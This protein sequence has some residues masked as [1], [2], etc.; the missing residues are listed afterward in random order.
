MSDSGSDNTTASEQGKVV[1][2]RVEV[3]LGETKLGLNYTFYRGEGARFLPM[4]DGMAAPDALA[5]LVLDGWMPDEPFIAPDTTIVAFGSCFAGHIGRYLSNLG[6]DV[7]TRKDDKAYVSKLGDG[8]VNVFAIRQQ[9][10]WAWEGLSP[11]VE[12]WHG[13]KAEEFGYDED[14]RGR[15]RELFDAADVFIITLGLSEI[16]YDEPTGEVFWRAVPFDKFDPARHKFRVASSAETLD[17]LRRIHDLI[18]KHRPE[19]AI[20][21]TVSPIPLSA[22][23]R[24]VSCVTASSASKALLRGAVDELYRERRPDDPKLFYY[25]AYEVVTQCFDRPFGDDFR[26]PL[27]HVLDVNMKAFERYF[28]RTGLTDADL[29]AVFEEAKRLDRALG[30][31]DSG[32][33]RQYIDDMLASWSAQTKGPNKFGAEDRETKLARKEELRR[34]RALQKASRIAEKTAGADKE[35][36]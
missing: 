6:F 18:R 3:R 13:Y 23:F 14:V 29:A 33:L 30:L 27:F 12:L 1:N 35:P 15:T 25:P 2:G 17:N 24:P 20:V 34:E 4:R 28:C 26:H 11:S 7:A 10:E 16:W 19:A 5:R 36:S 31:E 8:I 9:F 21:F 22:T 32:P